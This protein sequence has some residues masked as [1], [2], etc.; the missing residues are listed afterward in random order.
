M[1]VWVAEIRLSLADCS[2]QPLQIK[3]V[4]STAFHT[5][6]K[7]GVCVCVCVILAVPRAS[8]IHTDRM[9]ATVVWA[10]PIRGHLKVYIRQNGKNSENEPQLK[11]Y[12]LCV[13]TEAGIIIRCTQYFHSLTIMKD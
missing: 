4:A 13:F 3:C 1:S 5:L 11:L 10:H 2:G 12:C 7:S 8:L 6:E 9:S